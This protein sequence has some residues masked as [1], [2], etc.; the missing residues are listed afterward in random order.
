MFKTIGK[1]SL[2]PHP[3]HNGPQSA[4]YRDSGRLMH[5]GT[6]GENRELR[7]YYRLSVGQKRANLDVKTEVR[8]AGAC[9]LKEE[10]SG[11]F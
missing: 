11:R 6:G 8:I 4:R 3:L 9:V 5:T 2:G 7:Y 10:W 1:E